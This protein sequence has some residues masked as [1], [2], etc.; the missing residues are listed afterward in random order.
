VVRT[1]RTGELGRMKN[2]LGI[3]KLIFYSASK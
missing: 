3:D 1:K 2:S